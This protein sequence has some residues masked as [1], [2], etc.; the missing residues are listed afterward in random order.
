[1]PPEQVKGKAQPASDI[2]AMGS[3]LYFLLVGH[4]PQALTTSRPRSKVSKVSADLDQLISRMTALDLVD[5]NIDAK[6]VLAELQR[7][8]EAHGCLTSA[9]ISINA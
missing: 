6:G 4:D 7:I 1:M 3:T 5:R 2:Y 9:E 8:A